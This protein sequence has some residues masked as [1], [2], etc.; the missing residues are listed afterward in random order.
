MYICLKQTIIEVEK[1][2]TN[3]DLIKEENIL[4]P[5]AI[6]FMHGFSGCLHYMIDFSNNKSTHR[7]DIIQN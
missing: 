4:K 3:Q 7:F 1:Q 5:T 2:L 6:I